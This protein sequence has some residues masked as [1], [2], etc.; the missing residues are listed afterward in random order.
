MPIREQK[1]LK[2]GCHHKWF[3]RKE[4]R[5]HQCPNC[6]S[7]NWDVDTT[8]EHEAP[9]PVE[10]SWGDKEKLVKHLKIVNTK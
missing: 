10:V 5:P 8:L 3:P 4:G 9:E 6:H 7:V 1:C 2:K